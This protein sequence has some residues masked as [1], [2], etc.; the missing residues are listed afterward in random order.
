MR[1]AQDLLDEING[2]DESPRIE[3][4]RSREVG[5]SLVETV[6]AF[7]NEPGMGG[8]WLLLGVDSAVNDKGDVV[9]W[10]EG[11]SDP[12][13]VQKDLVCQCS[14]MLNQVVRPV[15]SSERI[16]GK[17]VLT[18]FVPEAEVAQKPVYLKATGLPKG[19]WRRIGSTDQRCTDEDLWVLRGETQARQ[20]PDH[21]IIIDARM[22]DFDAH[23][24]DAYRRERARTNAHAEELSYSDEELLEALG[25]L[26]RVDG[27]LRPTLAGIVLFGKTMALRRLLPTLRIDYIRVSGTE[28]MQDPEQRF[29]SIDIRKPLLLA[30][31]LAEASI[32]DELPRGFFLREGELQSQQEPVLPRKVV[33]EAVANAVMHRSYREHSPMQIVR[34]S[35]RIDIHNPGYALKDPSQIGVPGST[36]RNPT[37]AAVLHDLNWAEAKGTG[38][39]SMR[40]LSAEA[41][42]PLPEFHS[43]R[44]NNRFKATLFLHHLLTAED[45]VWLKSL[46][47]EPLSAEDAKTLVYARQTGAVDNAA[48]RDFSGLDTLQASGVLRRLRDRGLLEKQGGGSR[49]Y[50]T[51]AA[52]G[53]GLG[54]RLEGQESHDETTDV[55]ESA[56]EDTYSHKLDGDSHNV[57][58]YPHNLAAY[59]HNL[60]GYPHNLAA[61]STQPTVVIGE[62][63]RRRIAAAGVRPR[64][65]I[66]RALILELCSLRP[67][68][69][70]E[71]CQVLGRRYARQLTRE[72]L[73][74]LRTAGQLELLYPES[75]NHPHQAYTAKSRPRHNA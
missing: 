70:A 15:I 24:I 11:L 50:Y 5:R 4:K 52:P 36:L 8:G 18:V 68:S 28:W 58:P 56:A 17:P 41:G 54:A 60:S 30:M 49:T 12:D 48:C 67:F 20:G 74:P 39:R 1:S 22:D 69:A 62:D 46:T 19:A 40:R 72:H 33:R 34:Y 27:E 29:H 23:A 10:P 53:H 57:A 3:A 42:L 64:R 55:G 6:I 63:L 73:K 47:C 75:E 71:L 43:D 14:T 26:R 38:I 65:A 7:A 31:P 59:P 45:H 44:Q 9:Y 25:A 16:Q 61:K 2:S 37:I 32:V 51:L 21:A 66:L 35:N 13:K